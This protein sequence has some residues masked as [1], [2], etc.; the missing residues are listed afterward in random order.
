MHSRIMMQS[1][2]IVLNV[3]VYKYVDTSQIDADVQPS[4]VRVTVKG[5]VMQLVLP[6][7][8]SPV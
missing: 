7:D 8:V 6:E 5:K 1:Q 3:S 4:Y 2:D